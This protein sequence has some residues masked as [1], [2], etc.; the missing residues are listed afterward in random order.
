MADVPESFMACV[1]RVAKA[2]KIGR[3]D[4]L[5]LLQQVHDRGVE[6][7]QSGKDDPF[8]AAAS[9]LAGKERETAR[10]DQLDAIR[11]A[12]K[13]AAIMAKVTGFD[14]AAQTL[15]D[16]LHGSNIG[17]RENV[18][19]EWL[20]RASTVNAAIDVQMKKAGVS[21]AAATGKLDR[22]VARALWAKNA[23]TESQASAPAKA[24]ADAYHPALE[25][26]RDLQNDH[27]ARIGAAPDYA[28]HTW[29]D[30]LLMRRGGRGATGKIEADDA[31][32]RWWGLTEPKLAEKTF[33][34]LEPERGETEAKARLRFGRSVFDALVSG[35][36][37]R[38]EGAGG[39][40]A[41]EGGHIQPAFEGT[42]NIAKR[43]SQ[44]RVLFWKDADSWYDYNQQYG[45]YRTLYEGV[46]QTINQGSRN[47]AL[48]DK[49]G[50]NP[51]GSL[52]LVIRRIQ[53][54]YRSDL[55]GG[56]KFTKE[57]PGIQN[58]MAR[59]DGSANIPIYSMWHSFGEGAREYY[60]MVSLGGVGITHAASIWATVPSELRHHGIGA[61]TDTLGLGNVT[62]SLANIGRVGQMLVRGRGPMERQEIVADLGA[63]AGGLQYSVAR[64]WNLLF[65]Q[66][67]TP[68]GRLSAMHNLF[69]K[70][71]GIRWLYDTVRAGVREFA[72]GN[73]GRQLDRGFAELDPH[74]QAMLGKYGINEGEWNQLR[75]LKGGLRTWEGRTYLTPRD[76]L[77]TQGGQELADKLLMYYHDIGDHAVV[78]PGVRERAALYGANRPGSP[79]YE[80]VRLATQFK[81]WPLAAVNQI[82]GR[83]I[84]ASLNAKDAAWG[85][86]LTIAMSTMGGYTRMLINDLAVGNTP[87]DP[88]EPG[89]LLAGLA[90]GGGLGILGD[91]VFGE[92][93]RL[94]A[95]ISA[96]IGGPML[97]DF[98]TL[99]RIFGRWRNNMKAG[100]QS[101][102]W[103]DL[104]RFAKSHVPFANLVYLKG[105][106]DYLLWFHL[107]EASQPG[108]WERMNQRMSREQGR[109]MSGYTPGGGVPLGIP[110]IYMQNR[111]G[112]TFGALG[113]R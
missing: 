90:Q 28:I 62:G 93:T 20:G 14:N 41:D 105:A 8:L 111:S 32:A 70:A 86:G 75:T 48:M 66:G 80:L 104:A 91:F 43:A 89:T 67:N 94:D 44:Q 50:T 78:V 47:I 108:W 42:H 39:M 29:H 79:H 26:I 27:G 3:D 25:Q 57:V 96:V 82:L 101:D 51:G 71:T 60:N 113:Q 61:G 84:Y 54:K 17:N 46:Q 88:R 1:A 13:R 65:E 59:L 5:A 95:G 74:L 97:A 55:D 23:K 7:M 38:P 76:A 35:I 73:L 9:E 16:T 92:T 99:V 18:Q 83:E 30:P 12:T 107:L 22:E 106:L 40:P 109:T 34:G 53:E 52:N 19:S 77:S 85:L 4:A 72:A 56:G 33:E 10:L 15:R 49:F 98:D 69:M 63:Y 100:R 112:Q 21:D 103:P 58:V 64:N 81:I 11:N 68:M 2:G 102:F 45:R 37:M 110:G 31:F 36:H 24:M 6:M 87:R